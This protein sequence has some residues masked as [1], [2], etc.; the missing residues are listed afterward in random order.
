MGA[1]GEEGMK[2]ITPGE[3]LLEEYL[4]PKGLTAEALAEGLGVGVGEVREVLEGRREIAEELSERLGRFFGQSAGFWRGI[5]I[6]CETRRNGR[7]G[8]N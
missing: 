8:Q 1:V 7:S 5:E 6:E 2:P 4:K 3:I